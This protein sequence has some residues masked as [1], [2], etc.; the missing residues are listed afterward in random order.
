[1]TEQSE[2]DRKDENVQ[3]H[4]QMKQK[5]HQL[6][7]TR[8]VVQKN[9][10]KNEHLGLRNVNNQYKEKKQKNPKIFVLELGE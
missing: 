7:V 6:H 3:T 1:M 9:F 2:Q 5:S 10:E 8:G 4:T